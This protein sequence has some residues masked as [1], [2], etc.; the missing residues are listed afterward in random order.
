MLSVHDHLRH[1]VSSRANS[2]RVRTF[3]NAVIIRQISH[4]MPPEPHLILHSRHSLPTPVSTTAQVTHTS[5]L[6]CVHLESSSSAVQ[7]RSISIPPTFISPIEDDG[8]GASQSSHLSLSGPF[9][10]EGSPIAVTVDV[11]GSGRVQK[12]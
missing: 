8:N 11:G 6:H 7:P 12:L 9:E 1:S 3:P 10:I 4:F 2:E 5:L